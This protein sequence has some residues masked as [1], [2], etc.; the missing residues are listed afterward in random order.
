SIDIARVKLKFELKNVLTIVLNNNILKN[1][2]TDYKIKT[3]MEK[4]VFNLLFK[5][6]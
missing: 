2:L 1:I 4:K 5:E 3:K 6:S